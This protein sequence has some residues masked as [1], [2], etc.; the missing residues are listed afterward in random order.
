MVEIIDD[1]R[2][3]VTLEGHIMSA[4]DSAPHGG[5][6]LPHVLPMGVEL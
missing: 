2:H 1:T 4:N 6:R 5:T 3:E